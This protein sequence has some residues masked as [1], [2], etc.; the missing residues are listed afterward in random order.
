MSIVLAGLL[1]A[2]LRSS[3]L[4]YF[5]VSQRLAH[6]HRMCLLNWTFLV[7]SPHTAPEPHKV[8]RVSKAVAV[9][10]LS[11]LPFTALFSIV[12]LLMVVHCTK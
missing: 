4:L 2:L 6:A 1:Q 12:L 5:P 10:S 11:M 3:P 9:G 7:P 8:S